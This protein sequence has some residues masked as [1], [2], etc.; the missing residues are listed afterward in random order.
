M[1]LSVVNRAGTYN[2]NYGLDHRDFDVETYPPTNT[3]E[4]AVIHPRWILVDMVMGHVPVSRLFAV[5]E[6]LEN[7]PADTPEYSVDLHKIV[8][9]GE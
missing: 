1:K 9:G 4:I 2:E 8:F 7:L 5:I 6:Y 3:V